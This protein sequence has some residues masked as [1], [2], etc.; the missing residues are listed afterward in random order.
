MG[1]ARVGT[2]R[3]VDANKEKRG[4]RE[5]KGKKKNREVD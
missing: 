5:G 4:R 3:Q 1:H 2:G